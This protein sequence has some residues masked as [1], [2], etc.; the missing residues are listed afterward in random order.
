L[1]TSSRGSKWWSVTGRNR[2]QQQQAAVADN[3]LCCDVG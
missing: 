2:R 3:V 1:Q